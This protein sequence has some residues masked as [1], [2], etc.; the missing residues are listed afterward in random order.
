MDV[1]PRETMILSCPTGKT[2]RLYLPSLVSPHQETARRHRSRQL[3][4]N[5]CHAHRANQK[6]SS[7]EYTDVSPIRSGCRWNIL[8]CRQS[9]AVVVGIYRCVANQKRSWFEY[10]DLPR[11]SCGP[12][13]FV[14]VRGAQHEHQAERHG[15][16]GVHEGVGREGDDLQLVAHGH[17]QSEAAVNKHHVADRPQHA[18]LEDARQR[19]D[20]LLGEGGPRGG[21]AGAVSSQ[22]HRVRSC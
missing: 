20:P 2:I 22:A 16:Q 3:S 17:K 14:R 5:V 4:V 1:T 11:A 6:R 18:A 13:A 8:S 19:E 12:E 21:H 9:E 7:L 15:E 10:T